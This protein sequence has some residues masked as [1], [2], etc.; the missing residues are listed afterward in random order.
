MRAATV[1]FTGQ[2]PNLIRAGKMANPNSDTKRFRDNDLFA[3]LVSIAVTVICAGLVWFVV[4]N[5]I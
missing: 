5:L 2:I 1:R 3:F 4:E